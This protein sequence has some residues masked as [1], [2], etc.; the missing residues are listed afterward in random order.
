[1]AKKPI[2]VLIADDHDVLSTGLRMLLESEG[3]EVLGVASTGREAV[4]MTLEKSPDVILLDL[5]MDEMDGLAAL[6]V[7]RYHRPEVGVIMLTSH[8]EPEYS[9]RARALGANAFLSKGVDL[10]LLVDTLVAAAGGNR[11]AY[12]EVLSPASQSLDSFGFSTHEA[13]GQAIEALTEK[14]ALILDLIARGYENKAILD[15][16]C[17]TRN[18]LKTHLSHIYDKLGVNDRTQAAIWALT[19]GNGQEPDEKGKPPIRT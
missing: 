2:R 6:T 3:L 1:M 4:D 11:P 14:E 8:S 18:T 13:D 7:I 17:I 12:Q 10:E 5:A 16:L 15:L 9:A 19:N